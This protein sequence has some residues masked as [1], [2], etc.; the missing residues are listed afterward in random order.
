MTIRKRKIKL[1]RKAKQR[2]IKHVIM[3]ALCSPVIIAI[4]LGIVQTYQYWSYDIV[5]TVL[6]LVNYI[7]W[8]ILAIFLAYYVS[9]KLI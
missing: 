9:Y 4:I 2:V 7:T 8:L 5:G 1:K 3:V 6:L